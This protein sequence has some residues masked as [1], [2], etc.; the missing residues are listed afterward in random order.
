MAIDMTG[1]YESDTELLDDVIALDPIPFAKPTTPEFE[2]LAVDL[3]T[4]LESGRLTNG[5][6][7]A[8]LERRASERL[9]VR[10]C[11]AVA[12]CTSGLMLVLRGADISGD[13]VL[14]SFT[15]VATAHAVVWNGLR[16]VFADVE[17]D[18]L[19]LSPLAA[20]RGLGVRTGAIL[21]THTFGTPCAT[22]ALEEVAKSNGI[23][24]F[25]DAAHAFGSLRQ[26]TP[27]GGFGDAEVFSLSPTKVL[28]SAEGG[29]IATND[30]LLAE[31]CRHGRDYGNP[32]DY[33]VRLIG[34]NARM[35]E[36]HAAFALHS[37]DRLDDHIAHRNRIAQT[38]R[39]AL[40]E[41]PGISFPTVSPGDT[42]TYKDF[43]TLID[44]IDFGM[45]AREVGEA[46]QDHGV[47]T[48]RYFSP[49]VH[50]MRAYQLQPKAVGDLRVTD[51]VSERVLTLPMWSDM[52]E[53]L[54][55]RVAEAIRTL[56]RTRWSEDRSAS[57][58]A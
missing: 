35:S 51:E 44:P 26:G 55:L 16:P 29:I 56:R 22:E 41:V 34:L 39:S 43:T 3:K 52:P 58:S 53:A 37:L 17:S 1:Q 20:Q 8:E 10:H 30:D 28:S 14:P 33:D 54:A 6:Y 2:E 57:P 49:P 27:I 25:F 21:A 38:Y 4:I 48:R 46:L 40:A 13:V 36:I 9:G 19:T 5:S 31:R 12:S 24:L 11:V 50:E 23:R 42:S 7:V 32:G 15:F 18:T 47:D 45:T